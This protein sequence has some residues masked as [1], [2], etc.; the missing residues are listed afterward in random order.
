MAWCPECRYEFVDGVKECPKC[1]VALVENLAAESGKEDDVF[2]EQSDFEELLE[3]SDRTE[4]EYSAEIDP[5]RE[6]A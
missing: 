6:D 2:S 4:M 1:H 5:A 3:D